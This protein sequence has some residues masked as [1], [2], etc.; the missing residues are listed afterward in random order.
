MSTKDS[1]SRN[2]E[3]SSTTFYPTL[4][5][6]PTASATPTASPWPTQTAEPTSV[7][8][9]RIQKFIEEG[10][11]AAARAR[12][13][14][15]GVSSSPA[16]TVSFFPTVTPIPT[17]TPYPTASSTPTISPFPSL[18]LEPTSNPDNNNQASSSEPTYFPTATPYPSQWDPTSSPWPTASATPTASPFPSLSPYPSTTWYPTASSTPTST[19]L[20]SYLEPSAEPS[21][22][23][24]DASSSPVSTD[25]PTT[26]PNNSNSDQP[27]DGGEAVVSSLG[28]SKSCE[29]A[30]EQDL[31]SGTETELVF[32]YTVEATTDPNADEEI[33]TFF[34]ALE[35]HLLDM[36]AQDTLQC[37]AS[38]A[39][40]VKVY[41]LSYS[42]TEPAS[43][44]SA[45]QKPEHVRSRSCWI[46]Q[47]RMFVTTDALS[48]HVGKYAVLEDIQAQMNGEGLV[49]RTFPQLTFTSYL[50]PEPIGAG[51]EHGQVPPATQPPQEPPEE[52][53]GMLIGIVVGVLAFV[54][55]LALIVVCIYRRTDRSPKSTTSGS[56][57]SRSRETEN[58]AVHDDASEASSI[59]ITE[60]LS[61]S[62]ARL[63]DVTVSSNA[64]EDFEQTVHRVSSPNRNDPRRRARN[65]RPEG[66]RRDASSVSSGSFSDMSTNSQGRRKKTA[67][68]IAIE[69]V[70]K[71][72]KSKRSSSRRKLETFE[73]EP[74]PSRVEFTKSSRPGG[75]G[76]GLRDSSASLFGD[77]FEAPQG[78]GNAGASSK[79]RQRRS[80]SSNRIV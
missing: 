46:V 47:T 2:L 55:I 36:A 22:E 79:Q 58:L 40:D 9:V 19:P 74:P 41:R 18:T 29:G 34:N 60:L 38:Q 20:P 3:A 21:S 54:G 31:Q 64:E 6:Y 25:A 49:T 15:D 52:T 35:I 13:A 80:G 11:E 56:S 61:R 71:N 77:P 51:G 23:G 37:D 44:T 30:T 7:V 17:L 53:S 72:R 39:F 62:K 68:E 66:R 1:K 65:G 10:K 45:C 14:R 24:D 12:Q 16:P 8:D 76:G 26:V 63:K 27:D 59:E 5:P 43:E 67:K 69:M 4:S 57:T 75:G 78:Y 48:A 70:E 33:G 73:D 42:D 28:Y 50:G 32:V